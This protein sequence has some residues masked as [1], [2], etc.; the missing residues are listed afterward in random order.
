MDAL[1]PIDVLDKVGA[2][3][4][5]V[6]LEDGSDIDTI[7]FAKKVDILGYE[8]PEYHITSVVGS[9]DYIGDMLSKF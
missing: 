7:E 6:V 1:E 8:A 5:G 3:K 2:P 9:L 4:N